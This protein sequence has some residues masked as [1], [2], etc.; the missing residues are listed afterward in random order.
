M[1][2]PELHAPRADGSS[3][4]VEDGVP[5]APNLSVRSSPRRFV[6]SATPPRDSPRSVV[7]TSQSTLPFRGPRQPANANTLPSKSI[8]MRCGANDRWPSAPA[9]RRRSMATAGSTRLPSPASGPRSS[10]NVQTPRPRRRHDHRP[11]RPG[12]AC[13]AN[14]APARAPSET[15][16]VSASGPLTPA[17]RVDEPPQP[18]FRCARAPCMEPAGGSPALLRAGGLRQPDKGGQL[19]GV[20]REKPKQSRQLEARL[21]ALARA[22][23]R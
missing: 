5:P 20:F 3:V 23:A 19:L 12:R 16:A 14:A 8:S 4:R 10:A 6:G 17:R 21:A 11:R 18:S 13:A 1:G 15:A 22:R 9:R 7:V 2:L